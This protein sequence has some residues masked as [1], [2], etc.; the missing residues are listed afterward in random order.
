[1]P[2]N[3]SSSSTLKEKPLRRFLRLLNFDK[4]D[5]FYVF[6]YSVF[7]GIINLS[8]PLGIQAIINLIA[9]GQTSTSWIVL[10]FII[11][12]ATALVGAMKLMQFNITELLQQRIFV[13]SAFE[14]AYRMPRLKVEN[15]RNEYAPELANRF[16]DTLSIQKGLPK[17]ITELSEALLQIFFG[18]ILVALYHPFFGLFSA[19]IIAL[20]SVVVFVSGDKGLKSSLTESKYKYK[21]AYWLQE[22]GRMMN[23]FKLVGYTNYPV[24]KTDKLVDSYLSYRKKHF[25]T[26]RIQ[27]ISVVVIK[28]LATATLLLIGG[29]LVINQEIN[30]GQFV[31]AEI[32]IIMLLGSLEKIVT[33]METI[34]D[35]LTSIEKIGAVTDLPLESEE[36]IDFDTISKP[37]EPMSIKL[38]HV[39]YYVPHRDLPVLDDI[40]VEAQPGEKIAIVGW[41]NSGKSTL[42]KIIA[43]LLSNYQGTICYNE[44]PRKNI[45]LTSLRTYMGDYFTEQALFYATLEKNITM[46]RKDISTQDIIT[47]ANR[48]GLLPYIQQLPLGLNTM[49]PSDGTGI[50]QSV[51]K[52]IILARCIVDNPKLVATESLF[53]ST[54]DSER[55]D[56][57]DIL[58]EGSWTLF[59]T[60]HHAALARRCDKVIV[61]KEGKVEFVGTFRELE[62]KPYCADLFEDY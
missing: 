44:I 18:L 37:G 9:I 52:R 45:S 17:I 29:W 13:R 31:A 62:E 30:I 21:V 4:R 15:I 54:T 57:I 49:I 10:T 25:T 3:N 43:G 35:V 22:L 24:E 53:S 20:L 6:M 39:S 58:L 56:L 60:T 26:L 12:I 16:F 34:F 8:M 2:E 23:S 19:L 33:S 59:S 27:I 11:A 5:I 36:G 48:V 14:F 32:V 1:M 40:N 61:M 55:N 51:I 46:G 47:V 28:T 42:I 50:P 38:K 41:N 7:A